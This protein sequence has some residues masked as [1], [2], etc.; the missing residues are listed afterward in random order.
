MC[1]LVLCLLRFFSAN[2]IWLMLYNRSRLAWI[3]FDTENCH[4]GLVYLNL[5]SVEFLWHV[6]QKATM[7]YSNASLPICR[8]EGIWRKPC[9]VSTAETVSLPNIF[10]LFL[11]SCCIALIQWCLPWQCRRNV[12]DRWKRSRWRHDLYLLQGRDTIEFWYQ[13]MA[14]DTLK[15]QVFQYYLCEFL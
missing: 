10:H 6:P 12:A 7:I 2:S 5:L 1:E 11:D 14:V 9:C 4:L 13:L 3:I 15:I 8:C